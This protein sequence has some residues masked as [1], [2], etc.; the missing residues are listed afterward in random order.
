MLCT[1]FNSSKSL[2]FVVSDGMK[3]FIL[4]FAG[5]VHGL[6]PENFT[7]KVYVFSCTKHTVMILLWG[8]YGVEEVAVILQNKIIVLLC[9]ILYP[10][11][12][13]GEFGDHDP[14][15][16]RSGYLSGPSCSN[17]G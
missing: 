12:V 17:D 4:F 13:S 1:T 8:I 5:L 15:A 16:S 10:F 11:L 3:T 14:M 9:N 6:G 7:P 2:S